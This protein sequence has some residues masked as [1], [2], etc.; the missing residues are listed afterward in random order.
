LT[1]PSTRSSRNGRRVTRSDLPFAQVW[2]V[3]FEFV[4]KSGERPDVVC[5][6]ARELWTR[7][8]FKLW[9]NEIDSVPPYPTDASTLFV[10]FVANAECA[11]HLA[12]N[13]PLPARILDLSPEFRN[14]T[15]GR[16]APEGKGL[17]GALAYY[18]L[19]AVGGK[20]KDAMQ[21]R[22]MKGWPFTAEE[23]AQIL[24][25][26]L[27]DVEALERLL[28]K[29]LPQ[30]DLGVALY[31]GEFVAS[32]ALMEHRGVPLDRE[33]FPSLADQAIWNAVRDAMVPAIDKDYGVYVRD[34]A[35]NWSFNI[36]QFK[37]YLARVGIGW[38]LLETGKLNM[39]RKVW[40]DQSR[41]HPQLENLRQLRHTR[42]KMRKV[43]L[44][45]GHDHCNR[46]TL[47]SFKSKTSRTQPKA[48]LWIFSPAVWLRSLIKPEPGQAVAYVDWSSMEFMIAA[49]L[50]D[51]PV[52]L[53]F[54]REG[55]PYLSFAK[56]VGAAPGTAT[57]STHA[58]LRDRY[59]IG[60]LA[61]QYGMCAEALAGRL[62]ISVFEA[63]EMINQH[64]ELFAQYWRWSDDWVARALDTGTMWTNFGWMCRTGILEFNER[65]IR[66]WPVQASGAEILRIACVLGP[67]HGVQLL[68][69][70]H[71][72][73]LIGSTIERIEADV[74]LMRELMRRASRIVLNATADGTRE[75]RTDAKIICHPDRYSDPRGSDI[76]GWVL[77]KLA[78]QAGDKHGRLG[79][80]A[81]GG[82]AGGAAG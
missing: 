52:M 20:R 80:T 73:V 64:H 74:A 53:A 34:K 18:G 15:N 30:I 31:R 7:Q 16:L 28:P 54:Y 69:P 23:R 75:L 70:V 56:R 9:R 32:S 1:A 25:Y 29:M 46:T 63:H 6:A 77:T 39:K 24:D 41:G 4:S 17:L 27:S 72:A 37:A 78:E 81:A 13:W 71:D 19:D 48:S 43:K 61:I 65:S 62:G 5:L 44:A 45:V 11:C 79:Q 35:G 58:L 14:I 33:I 36:E 68:A 66:N 40:E 49:C 22:V 26:C 67:R 38:P 82:A 60:L 76:W 2:C 8:T 55:D 42:D 12:L 59:K 50:S 10:C 3:D 57:K 47:W 51:D 21:K